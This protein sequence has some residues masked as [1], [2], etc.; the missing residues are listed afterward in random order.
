MTAKKQKS[1]DGY[2][3]PKLGHDKMSMGMN[4][5]GGSDNNVPADFKLQEMPG[6]EYVLEN[7]KI[8]A[9]SIIEAK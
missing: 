2:F 3:G 5:K 8:V 6:L 7:G 9:D 4:C 1:P